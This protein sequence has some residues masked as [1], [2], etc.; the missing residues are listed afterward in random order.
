MGVNETSSRFVGRPLGRWCAVLACGALALAG[1]G[2]DDDDADGPASSAEPSTELPLIVVTT[3]ILGDVV[4]EAVGDAAE[5]VTIM[6]VG[7]DPHGFQASA[8]EVEVMMSAD[9]LIVNGAG[10]EES[11]LDVIES[12]EGDGV[13]IFEA[14]SAVE[15]IEFGEVG[16]DHE[17]AD[18]DE[19]HA[20]EDHADEDERDHDHSGDD[21][22]FWTDP[23]RMASAVGG[24]VGFLQDNVEFA[25]PAA[26]DA[27]AEAY[28]AELTALHD[29]IEAMVETIPEGDRKLVLNHDSYGYFADSFGFELIG[30]VIPGGSTLEATS[31]GELAELVELI[32]DEGVPAIFS[33]SSASDE[34]IQVLADEAGGVVVVELLTGSLGEPDSEG[35]TY[36]DM[37]RTNA[38]RIVTALT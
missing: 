20:D 38:E 16:H 12:A 4:S 33:D 15:T 14:I 25:D 36:L 23:M 37:Q 2:G 18:E 8:Q 26:V 19:D 3:S 29:E 35:A 11:L 32:D 24:I 27:S 28:V 31:G 5:V 10:L 17:H 30:V 34:L 6:P 7:A 1:C 22:H 9:A 13:P 21:P